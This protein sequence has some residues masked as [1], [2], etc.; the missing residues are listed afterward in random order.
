VL[1]REQ[2]R[3][4]ELEAE[5]R[6]Y[7]DNTCTPLFRILRLLHDLELG[8]EDVAR[9]EWSAIAANDFTDIPRDEIWM[10]KIALLS[11]ACHAVNDD[12][13]AYIL[14]QMLTPYAGRVVVDG[15][16][17]L[18]HCAVTHYLGLLATTLTDW[19]LAESCFE[20][21]LVTHVRMD[22]KALAAHTRYAF[23]DMLMRRNGP[24]DRERARELV[25]EAASAAA[26]M[27][28]TRLVTLVGA[29]RQHIQTDA[30]KR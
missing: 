19:E 6:L 8:H 12:R 21:A 24:G 10:G 1:R 16:N 9:A 26:Q 13:R 14:S 15:P 23:A 7:R 20:S 11:E 29:L 30:S 28:M 4:S 5:T 27:G 18:C 2:A 25:D 22:L 3:L 17:S